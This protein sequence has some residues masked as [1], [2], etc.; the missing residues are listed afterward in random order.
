[1]SCEVYAVA[2]LNNRDNFIKFMDAF[3]ALA[4]QQL[5]GIIK[6]TPSDKYTYYKIYSE[7]GAV[8]DLGVLSK[9][10]VLRISQDNGKQPADLIKS[11]SELFVKNAHKG[12]ESLKEFYAKRGKLRLVEGNQAITKITAEILEQIG[13]N[14]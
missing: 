3:V 12:S 1:M 2:P 6:E 4:D 8:A 5:D 10:A 13:A 9:S 7:G 11:M 14:V